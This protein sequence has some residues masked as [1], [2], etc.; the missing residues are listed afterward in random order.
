[1]ALKPTPPFPDLTRTPEGRF[2]WLDDRLYH[3]G[4]LRKIGSDG[5]AVLVVLAL[6]ADKRGASF[7]GRET[8]ARTLGIARHDLDQAL[9]R[10]IQLKLVAHKPWR[11]KHP[12]GVWQLLPIPKPNETR[13]TGPVTLKDAIGNIEIG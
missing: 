8:M 6:L 5:S 10:L 7:C 9:G 4:W 12:D 2:G 1:M 11:P 13:R 3:E